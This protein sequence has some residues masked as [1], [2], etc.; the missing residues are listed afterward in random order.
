[1]EIEIERS[2]LEYIADRA[3]ELASFLTSHWTN[4]NAMSIVLTAI[5]EKVDELAK[6]L[7]TQAETEE[8]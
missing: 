2:D 6:E 1:M 7:D 3:D 5:F 8:A 4:F